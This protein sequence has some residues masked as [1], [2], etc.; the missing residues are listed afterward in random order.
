MKKLTRFLALAIVFCYCM[1]AVSPLSYDA[2]AFQPKNEYRLPGASEQVIKLFIVD[3]VLS[4]VFDEDN[5]DDDQDNSSSAD[6]ILLKKKRALRSASAAKL[7]ALMSSYS[8]R[9]GVPDEH[10]QTVLSCVVPS[11]TLPCPPTGYPHLHS[12]I[13]PPSA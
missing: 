8:V 5:R 4:M 2:A 1:Y 7:I 10:P 11:G 13:S 12:G 3:V 6:R 9:P